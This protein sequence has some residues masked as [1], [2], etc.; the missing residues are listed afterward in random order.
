MCQSFVLWGFL[1]VLSQGLSQ[2]LYSFAIIIPKILLQIICRDE[3][4][5]RDYFCSGCFSVCFSL[6]SHEGVPIKEGKNKNIKLQNTT[7]KAYFSKESL[8]HFL[9]ASLIQLPG[10][11]TRET[12]INRSSM[13]NKQE[14]TY[15]CCPLP[16]LAADHKHSSQMRCTFLFY[17]WKLFI[18]EIAIRLQMRWLIRW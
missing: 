11:Y 3:R 10:G 4:N 16:I 7:A 15:F 5:L 1:F 18:W 14:C 2:N 6:K 17:Q 8:H 13:G 9:S 12:E